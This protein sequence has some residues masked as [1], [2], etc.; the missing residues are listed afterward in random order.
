MSDFG[1]LLSSTLSFTNSSLHH[2]PPPHSADSFPHSPFSSKTFPLSLAPFI[3]DDF[4]AVQD[5]NYTV[6][7]SC[8]EPEGPAVDVHSR[9]IC[10]KIE[11]I[12]Q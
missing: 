5:S 3:F 1:A 11:Y 7:M 2:Q 9:C 10:S 12:L 6:V 4:S 8:E